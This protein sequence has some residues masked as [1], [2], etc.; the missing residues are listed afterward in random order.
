MRGN[1]DAMGF[2]LVVSGAFVATTGLAAC[3]GAVLTGGADF[4]GGSG[5]FLVGGAVFVGALLAGFVAL[6]EGAFAPLIIFLLFTAILSLKM[7]SGQ[8]LD[9]LRFSTDCC[10]FVQFF[11]QEHTQKAILDP[12]L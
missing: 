1:A 6:G 11:S 9:G 8:I 3:L 7:S 12:I 10:G 4:L 2:A 5:F